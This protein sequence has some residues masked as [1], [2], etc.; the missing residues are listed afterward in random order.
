MVRVG[1]NFVEFEHWSLSTLFLVG[2][3]KLKEE[4]WESEEVLCFKIIG[5][6]HE[7]KGQLVGWPANEMMYQALRFASNCWVP[8]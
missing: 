1:V 5:L 2:P 6:L 4:S 8:F 3:S 7:R